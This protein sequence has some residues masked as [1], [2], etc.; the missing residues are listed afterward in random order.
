MRKQKTTS[1]FL[2]SAYFHYTAGLEYDLFIYLKKNKS[3]AF[4]SVVGTIIKIVKSG[5]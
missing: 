2:C 1:R 5:T 3:K 4:V